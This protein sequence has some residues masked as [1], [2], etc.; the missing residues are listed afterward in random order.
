MWGA[1]ETG[2]DGAA[3][4][5]EWLLVHH[6]SGF[7]AGSADRHRAGGETARPLR[8]EVQAARTVTERQIKKAFGFQARAFPGP[9][10]QNHHQGFCSL[11]DAQPGNGH[12]GQAAAALADGQGKNKSMQRLCPEGQTTKGLRHSPRDHEGE[13]NFALLAE[14]GMGFP[15]WSF[16]AE[17]AP[18]KRDSKGGNQGGGVAAL[19]LNPWFSS[20]EDFAGPLAYNLFRRKL[21]SL[22]EIYDSRRTFKPC[23]S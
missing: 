18:R 20:L 9:E 21:L 3:N 13:K 23:N 7:D 22:G 11:A 6:V 17:G 19:P 2:A 14:V 1:P 8:L 4:P 5:L 10:I 12:K 16:L 15:L